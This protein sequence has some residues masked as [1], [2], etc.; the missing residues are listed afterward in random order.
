MPLQATAA[1]AYAQV[2]N[3]HAEIDLALLDKMETVF[4]RR[5]A[6]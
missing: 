2:W 1:S 5:D 6:L 3:A 4:L